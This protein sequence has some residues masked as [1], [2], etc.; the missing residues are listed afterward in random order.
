MFPWRSDIGDPD[1]VSHGGLGCN[2]RLVGVDHD[3]KPVVASNHDGVWKVLGK[4]FEAC[5]K[6]VL[7]DHE[8]PPSFV[9]LKRS[10]A[11]LSQASVRSFVR[12][13]RD[14]M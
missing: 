4:D 1:G 14:M 10:C 8:G 2:D 5:P 11:R 3:E 9:F 7:F 6:K 13:G 12:D